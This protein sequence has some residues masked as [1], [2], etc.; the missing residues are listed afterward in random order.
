M[1]QRCEV[2]DM[3]VK[4]KGRMEKQIGRKNKELQIGNVE[5]D[6]V[7]VT[8]KRCSVSRSPN[9]YVNTIKKTF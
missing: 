1:R 2:L 8:S 4:W 3:L 6:K 7:P 5:R 9:A